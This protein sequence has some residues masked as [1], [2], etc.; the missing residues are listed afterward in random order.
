MKK[1]FKHLSNAE[2]VKII[3]KRFAQ[4]LNDDDYVAEL[5][6]RRDKQGFKIIAKY[7]TYEIIENNNTN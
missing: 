2:L 5:C 6:Y 1:R 7:D 3:N 4:G